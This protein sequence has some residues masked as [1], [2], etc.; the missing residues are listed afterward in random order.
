MNY[1]LNQ[2]RIYLKIVETSSITKAADMLFL[3]QPAVSIQLK[4]FQDQFDISLTEVVGRRLYI[5]DFGREIA[6]AAEKILDQVYAINY[7]TL[8]YKGLLSGRLRIAVASTG[9]YVMPYFLSGF[10]NDNPGIDLVMDV[11][12]KTKVLESL[13]RNEID[14]ALVSTLPEGMGLHKIELITNKL[15]LVGKYPPRISPSDDVSEA[16]G[17]S[18]FI[19]REEGSATRAAMQY[20]LESNK[21]GFRRKLELTSNEAVKQAVLAGLGYSLM[22]LISLKNELQN[23]DLTIIPLKELPL[24]TMWSLIWL[25]SKKLSIAATAFLT[26]LESDKYA[27]AK[28]YFEWYSGYSDPA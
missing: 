14:F 22:P 23:K 13:A 7:K 9:K 2:L 18:T 6:D 4:N 16:L 24:E 28:K 11:T 8:A 1:T 19:F 20:F 10:I 15:C 21:I 12:N 17:Q 25:K 5:T 26:R 3:T 27:I